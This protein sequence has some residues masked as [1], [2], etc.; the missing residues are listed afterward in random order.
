MVEQEVL[1]CMNDII[2][3]V[4]KKENKRLYD[5]EYRKKN[6]EKNREKVKQI[7]KKYYENNR[8]KIIEQQKEYYETENG[9]KNSKINL[10]KRRG[11]VCD[12]F[13]ALYDHYTSTA[14]CDA[15]RV[16]LTIDKKTTSTRKCL[17]HCHETG[18]FRNILCHSCNNKRRQNNF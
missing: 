17:D 6:K 13:D 15:C 7:R 8:E 9:F 1:D 5:K 18:L 11:V 2:N 16:E 14:Y 3:T 4:V 12:N 10:W